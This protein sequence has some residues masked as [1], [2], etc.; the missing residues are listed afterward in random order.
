[1]ANKY[2]FVLFLNRKFLSQSNDNE[3]DYVHEKSQ[4]PEQVNVTFPQQPQSTCDD[5]LWRLTVDVADDDA[6]AEGDQQNDATSGIV[7]EQLKHV[8]AALRNNKQSR[9][10]ITWS[11]RTWSWLQP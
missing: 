4:T 6:L 8:H 5:N 2:L 7:V 9:E 11:W 1:M 3:E 10:S